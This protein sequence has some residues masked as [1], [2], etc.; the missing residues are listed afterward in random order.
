MSWFC[1]M[2]DCSCDCGCPKTDCGDGT[3]ELINQVTF[4]ILDF[5]SSVSMWW[6]DN[7][8]TTPSSE[9]PNEL[10]M[11]LSFLNGSYIILKEDCEWPTAPQRT[12]VYT[13]VPYTYHQYDWIFFDECPSVINFT[14]VGTTSVTVKFFVSDTERYIQI[15]PGSV[16]GK[17]W[18]FLMTGDDSFSPCQDENLNYD[19]APRAHITDRDCSSPAHGIYNA[20][21]VPSV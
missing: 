6:Y 19:S 1:A 15:T 11:D 14:S 8:F 21:T 17:S 5:G 20:S 4:S 18:G 12:D 2:A 10:I 7:N 16:A 9:A 3:T 13:D